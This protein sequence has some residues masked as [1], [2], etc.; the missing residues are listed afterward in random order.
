MEGERV[1][2]VDPLKAKGFAASPIVLAAGKRWA[3]NANAVV[4]L[5]KLLQNWIASAPISSEKFLIANRKFKADFHSIPGEAIG[6]VDNVLC[7]TPQGLALMLSMEVPGARKIADQCNRAYLELHHLCVTQQQGSSISLGELAVKLKLDGREMGRVAL[8]LD[9]MCLVQVIRDGIVFSPNWHESDYSS[10]AALSPSM[11]FINHADIWSVFE[12]Y[13]E[14]FAGLGMPFKLSDDITAAQ[15]L[16]AI[17]GTPLSPTQLASAKAN[18]TT[19]KFFGKGTMHDAYVEFRRIFQSA[20]S[21]LIVVDPYVDET[22]FE[23]L[24]TLTASA[25]HVQVLTCKTQND[26]GLERAKFLTQ[27]SQFNLEVRKTKEFH[28]RFVVV[29]DTDIY[30]VGASI[31]DAGDKAFMYSKIDAKELVD[32]IKAYVVSVWGKAQSY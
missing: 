28:D 32:A 4:V 9:K 26:F 11:Q 10:S 7:P 12:M 22:F 25:M 31:K 27:Y 19:Q 6:T 15:E 13:A 29:D 3:K 5:K 16:C 24:K 2:A 30:H 8:M 17:D 1:K 14:H 18:S 20:K 23:M 21:K